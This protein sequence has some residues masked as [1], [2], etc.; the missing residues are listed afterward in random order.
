MS[1]RLEALLML[2][3]RALRRSP[4]LAEGIFVQGKV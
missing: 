3:R 1:A 4:S 2:R